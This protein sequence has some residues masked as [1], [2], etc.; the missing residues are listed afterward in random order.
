LVGARLRAVR[1]VGQP[2]SVPSKFLQ[3]VTLWAQSQPDPVSVILFG[4]RARGDYGPESDWDIALVFEGECPSLDG[5]PRTLGG[6]DVEWSPI[7]RSHAIRR[8]NV[9]SVPH[10]VAA[11]GRCLH[12]VPL[13]VPERKDPNIPVTWHYLFEAH[14]EIRSGVRAVVDHWV[15]PSELRPHYNTAVARRSAMAGELLCKAVLSM[16]GVEPRRSHSVAELCEGLEREF[17]FDPLL[18]ALREC[19]GLTAKAHVSVYGDLKS[20]REAVGVSVRRLARVVRAFG[21]VWAAACDASEADEGRDSMQRLA[22][23]GDRLRE[24]VDWLC[25]SDCPQDI[26]QQVQAGLDMWP[27]TSELWQRLLAPRFEPGSGEGRPPAG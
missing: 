3:R 20:S 14:G 16:R 18:P 26:Q 2:E 9:C 24:D 1:T 25:S 19:D 5:L 13:P 21:R 7:E 6:R 11:D 12:G 4:S 22:A 27:D 17:P 23:L 8:L 10:A 15:L